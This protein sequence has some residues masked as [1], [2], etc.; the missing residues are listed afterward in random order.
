MGLESGVGRTQLETQ[1]VC[2]CHVHM[3]VSLT[4]SVTPHTTCK[5]IICCVIHGYY[6]LSAGIRMGE[7]TS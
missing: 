7:P 1:L 4:R 3:C 2:S 5:Q 6:R